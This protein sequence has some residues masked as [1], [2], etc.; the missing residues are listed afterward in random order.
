MEGFGQWALA[1][2]AALFGAGGFWAWLTSNRSA[3][4]VEYK[5]F[6]E[7][8]RLERRDREA[9]IADLRKTIRDQDVKI[10]QTNLDF[11][12]LEIHVARLEAEIV[13]LGGT[14]PPRPVKIPIPTTSMPETKTEHP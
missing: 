11:A 1:A 3:T 5:Q 13:R 8:L 4:S 2:V 9:A 14:P 12:A 7:D 10:Y 6:V